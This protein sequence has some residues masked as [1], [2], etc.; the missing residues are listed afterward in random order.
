VAIGGEYSEKRDAE[1]YTHSHPR[2]FVDYVYGTIAA[3]GGGGS[4]GVTS[5][6]GPEENNGSSTG[7]LR[8]PIFSNSSREDSSDDAQPIAW[9]RH[10]GSTTVS[11]ARTAAGEAGSYWL[12]SVDFA[13]IWN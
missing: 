7:D 2:L 6:L 4:I 1:I 13:N 11:W 9:A 8:F 12:Q 5:A 10:T 3:S